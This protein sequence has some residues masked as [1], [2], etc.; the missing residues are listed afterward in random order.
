MLG[1]WASLNFH[2]VVFSALGLHGGH[3]EMTHSYLFAPLAG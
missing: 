1:V 3:R 2:K